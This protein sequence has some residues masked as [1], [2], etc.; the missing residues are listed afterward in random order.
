MLADTPAAAATALP[1][2]PVDVGVLVAFG[3]AK[4]AMHV[5]TLLATPYG[6]HRDEFLYFAM[7]AHLQLWRMDF[8]PAIALL[9]RGVRATL[10]DSL[11]AIR[12]APAVAGTAV[13]ALAVLLARELGGRRF[14]Q[15][16]AALAVLANPLF[17]RTAALFQPVVLDQLWWTVGLYALVRLGRTADPRWWIA[18]G[19]A[20][21]LGLLSKFSVAFF[22]A[23]VLVALLATPARRALATRWPWLAALL[24]LLIGSPSLVGQLRLGFPVVSYTR[25][26]QTVQL[27][28]VSAF[29]FF[30]GQ[31]LLGPSVL[32]A[33]AG[34]AYLLA[35]REARPF[36]VVGWT[37]AA[38]F[39]ILALLHGKPYYVGPVYPTLF[40]AGAVWLERWA[41]AAGGSRQRRAASYALRGAAVVLVAGY[42]L[43]VL[44]LGL[45]V[46]P[47][48]EMARYARAMGVTSAVTTNRGEVEAL[49]QDY[50]DMLGWE[51]QVAA[52]ARVYRGL[53]PED[54]ARAV[55]VGDNYG[56]AGALEFYG[57]RYG[58]PP[59]I[60]SA[61]T[62]WFFGPGE[63]PG[64]VVIALG[65]EPEQLARFFE[66]V[67]LVGYVDRPWGVPEE[68]HV[69]ISLCRRPQRTLQEIWP[70]L[71]EQ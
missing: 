3:V 11:L 36:R 59:V 30:T 22:A 4:L 7:G 28:H 26:L 41:L 12:L 57:P 16:L 5:G 38:A 53:P 55:L 62:Y 9:A 14:A 29:D 18:L 64:E 31:F 1:R 54:R 50:A 48:A 13:L 58:L 70:S 45:P 40:A 42:G 37:C 61:G 15:A 20:G 47:P 17:M 56:E 6:F 39:G 43:A 25:E 44:P 51:D 32:L 67:S 71:R 2:P 27:V 33:A 65:D 35:G 10:G 24:A 21:G 52:V 8:P 69:P 19:V 68:R 46:L 60:S 66:S 63:R 34:L 23:S 49:P